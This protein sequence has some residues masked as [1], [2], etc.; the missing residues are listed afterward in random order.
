MHSKVLMLLEMLSRYRW[1]A[2]LVLAL[3]AFAET[4]GLFW[5]IGQH[6]SKNALAASLATVKQ[7]PRAINALKPQF[8]ALTSL[9]HTMM[10]VTKLI[11]SFES[12]HL[13]H[14]FLDVKSID[15]VK[16]KIY[17]A[18]YWILRSIL[19]CSSQISDL[20]AS[21]FEQVHV[22]LPCQLVL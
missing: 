7:L 3:A 1:D 11:V 8:K 13:Q 19:E 17:V 22:S 6:Q 16:S 12:W 20:R 2:K 18:A 4:F 21:R 10:K 14:E 5:L 9:T 15:Y